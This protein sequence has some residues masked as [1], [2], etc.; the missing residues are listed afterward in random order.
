MSTDVS[1]TGVEVGNLEHKPIEPKPVEK[2]GT[3]SGVKS[4]LAGGFGGMSAVLV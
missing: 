4:F 1:T 2:K 3:T